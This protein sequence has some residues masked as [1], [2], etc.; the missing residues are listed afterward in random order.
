MGSILSTLIDFWL[1]AFLMW[2]V[3]SWFPYNHQIKGFYDFLNRL[4][5]PVM[6]FMRKIV[7]NSLVF[8][9][10]DATPILVY[11]LART[12]KYFILVLL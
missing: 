1:L 11:L 7:G 4:V 8:G 10:I 3:L 2:L 12:I 6:Q 9:N 5:N